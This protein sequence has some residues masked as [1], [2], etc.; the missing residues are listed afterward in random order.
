MTP[1]RLVML[2]GLLGVGCDGDL[3]EKESVDRSWCT[4][5]WMCNPYSGAV[6]IEGSSQCPEGQVPA[7]CLYNRDTD[8]SD[9][10]VY[11]HDAELFEDSCLYESKCSWNEESGYYLV[12]CTDVL[13]GMP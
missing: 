10:D 5:T 8:V 2:V 9:E 3:F 4:T 13:Y 11:C 6:A 12:E 7:V 1:R